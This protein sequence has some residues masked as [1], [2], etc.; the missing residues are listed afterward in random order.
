ME[1]KSFSGSHI[2]DLIISNLSRIDSNYP[3][4]CQ[5]QADKPDGSSIEH[6][7]TITLTVKEKYGDLFK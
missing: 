2:Q 3:Y 1:I 6:G 4:N 7:P 5:I